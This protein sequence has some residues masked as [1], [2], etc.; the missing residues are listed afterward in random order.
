MS[1]T[2]AL[3]R[4]AAE[5]PDAPAL[6]CEGES[7]TYAALDALVGRI[8]AFFAAAP[9]GGIALDLSNGAA[10][11]V[12]F[13]AAARAGREGQVLDPAWPAAL[14]AEVIGKIR[15]GLIV[16][17]RPGDGLELPPDQGLAG[18]AEALGAK[19]GGRVPEPDA[20][21][22][23]YVGF[24]SGSTGMPKGYRRSHRSWTAS[25]DADT[26]EFGI[27]ADDVLLAPGALTHSLFLY[28]LA[29][30]LDA[31]AHV[32]LARAFR[33]RAV[34]ELARRHKAS[35][36]YGVPTQLALLLEVLEAD[37]LRLENPL[38]SLRLVLCSGAKWPQGRRAALRRLLPKADFAEFYGASELSFIT[39]ANMREEVPEGSVG[40]PF[41]TV[42]M[43]IVDRAGRPLPAG[44]TGLVFVESPFLFMGYAT[45]ESDDLIRHGAALSVGDMGVMDGRGFL[46]LVG[47]AKRM[48]VT[49]GK[50]LYPEEVERLLETHPAIRAAAVLGVPDGLRGERLVAF[51]SLEAGAQVG[52]A[53]LIAFLKPRLPLFKVPRRYARVADWPLT[54]S[55][56]TDFSA[57]ARLW[58]DQ[59]EGIA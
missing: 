41:H 53:E 47:R 32:I 34:V 58:P 25:F 59:C 20:D 6:T 48:I 1:I 46:T 2:R 37:G 22:A 42:K 43:S 28:A 23:F 31:G 26:A 3:A 38:A 55:G 7:L 19:G 52:Q 14:R 51:L 39:V 36:L 33:P 18:L 50:N 40:R 27:G 29:R 17:S 49:S 16:A 35:V 10:L 30:G 8:A 13:L 45:G 56:K 15:P 54:A 4:H 11:A 5:R 21:L 44:R 57:V 24:T 9:A 12:L